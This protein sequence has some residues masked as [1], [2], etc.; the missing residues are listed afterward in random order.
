VARDRIELPT[1]GFS[2]YLIPQASTFLNEIQ[3]KYQRLLWVWFLCRVVL[4]HGR[5]VL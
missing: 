1:R 4:S 3:Y 2:D 5:L